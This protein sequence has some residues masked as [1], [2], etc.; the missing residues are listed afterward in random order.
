MTQRFYIGQLDFL[1]QLN[2]LSS[3]AGGGAVSYA[4]AQ[5]LSGGQQAQAR[6]NIGFDAAALAVVLSGLSLSTSA[7]ITSSDSVL[8]GL[9]KLQAQV[10]L[11]APL[12]SPALTGTPT[13][14]TA[15]AGTNTTQIATTAFVKTAVDNLI[16]SAPGALDTLDELAAALGDD[17]DFAGTVTTALAGKVSLSGSYAD[18]SWI[19]SLEASKLSGTTLASNVVNASLNAIT[20]SGGTLAVTGTSTASSGFSLVSTNGF[21]DMRL[22]QAAGGTGWRH[23]LNND[24][25]LLVQR[26]TNG[27]TSATT[28]GTWSIS[29][30]AITGM[31]SATGQISSTKAGGG[32]TAGLFVSANQAALSLKTLTGATNGKTWDWVADTGSLFARVVNDADT[33]TTTWMQIN[34]TGTTVDSVSIGGA[35]GAESL[36]VVPVAS[37]VNRLEAR[38]NVTTGSPELRSEGGDTHIGLVYLTKGGGAH[39]FYT[40]GES[41]YPQFHVGNATNAVNYI[42]ALGAPTG[43]SPTISVDGADTNTDLTLQAKGTGIVT[44]AGALAVT[45]ARAQFRANT[46]PVSGIGVEVGHDG[47][48]GYITSF[49]RGSVA[50]KALNL[51]ASAITLQT[52]GVTRLSVTAAGRVNLASLPTSAAGLAAGDLW[53]DSGT[54]KVA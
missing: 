51:D 13:A 32:S 42:S 41:Y 19:T 45:G 43:S 52:G 7:A 35:T 36:R 46:V 6:S 39:T 22:L 40:G 12:A 1:E 15:S 3:E 4:T 11:R 54:L 33:V 17:A 24:G 29:G 18:P 9:G 28:F 5:S 53:N 2:A 44:V 20:P 10:T 34:R 27:F 14:P 8:S 21:G 48:T 16:A 47:T 37:A 23:T 50:Y 31:L 30:L 38:G 26:T 25:T 49:D